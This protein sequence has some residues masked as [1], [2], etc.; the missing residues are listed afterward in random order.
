MTML[1]EN[2]FLIREH[3][4]AFHTLIGTQTSPP[5]GGGHPIICGTGAGSGGPCEEKQVVK[6]A[7]STEELSL[8]TTKHSIISLLCVVHDHQFS[9][10]KV[11]SILTST[12]RKI[13]MQRLVS[14]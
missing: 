14:P 13:A 1:E 10:I 5:C 2:P 8:Y 6:P 9:G 3:S 4:V 7:V 11:P 12:T